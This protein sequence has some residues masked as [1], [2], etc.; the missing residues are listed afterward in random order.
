MPHL[1]LVELVLE[2]KGAQH[3][4]QCSES[5]LLLDQNHK[6]QGTPHLWRGEGSPDLPGSPEPRDSHL[7]ALSLSAIKIPVPQKP[8]QPQGSKDPPSPLRG[9][10][11]QQAC[12]ERLEWVPQKGLTDKHP[13]GEAAGSLGSMAPVASGECVLRREVRRVWNLPPW[14]WARGRAIHSSTGSPPGAPST[15]A[16]EERSTGNPWC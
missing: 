5:L 10:R 9:K 2:S 13:R 7:P 12:P 16:H 6:V 14:L 3:A 8:V 11:S 1:S 15:H 4:D